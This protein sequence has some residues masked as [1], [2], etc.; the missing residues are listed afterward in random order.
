MPTTQTKYEW[1]KAEKPST[2]ARPLSPQMLAKFGKLLSMI[3]EAD[4]AAKLPKRFTITDWDTEV[5]QSVK[6]KFTALKRQLDNHP[7]HR[8]KAAWSSWTA[9]RPKRELRRTVS[10]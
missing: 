3:G 1:T 4:L 8:R 6:A 5:S 2:A 10:P 9:L 7:S